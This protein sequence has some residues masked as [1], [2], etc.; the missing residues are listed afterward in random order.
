MNNDNLKLT[1]LEGVEELEIKIRRDI[2]I[3]IG[4]IFILIFFVLLLIIHKYDVA[5]RCNLKEQVVTGKYIQIVAV[6]KNKI[7]LVIKE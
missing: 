3:F 7:K 1:D 5:Q 4:I 2:S 6:D